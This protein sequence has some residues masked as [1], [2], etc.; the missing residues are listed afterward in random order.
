MTNTPQHDPLPASATRRRLLQQTMLLPWCAGAVAAPAA[1]S[2]A[3]VAAPAAA[4]APA[5]SPPPAPPPA[6]PLVKAVLSTRELQ[7]DLSLLATL[8]ETLHPGLLRFQ[9]EADY[10]ARRQSLHQTFSRDLPLA[11]A[12]RELSRFTAA[13]RCGHTY[14]NFYNQRRSVQQAL[15]AGRDKLPFTFTWLGPRMVATGGALARGTEVLAIDGT[16]VAD[17][18]AQLLPLVRTDGN[19][20]AKKLALLSVRG[21][22]AWETFDIFFAQTFGARDAGLRRFVLD[23]RLPGDADQG[24]TRRL[25]VPA[26]GLE[27]RR[28]AVPPQP[29]PSDATPP[30]QLRFESSGS[31]VLTMGGWALYNSRWDWQ[32][33]LNAVLD[34]VVE[35]RSPALVVDLRDNEGGMDCGDLILA[36]C[37]ARV[38]R[39]EGSERLVRYRRVPDALRAPLDTWDNNF[40]DWGDRV[41]PLAGARE[42]RGDGAS[43]FRFVDS[44]TARSIEP[45]G[46]RFAGALRVL[47]S[48]TNSSATFR[49]AQLVRQY[50][51][52]TLIGG[53]TGGNQRGITGG[54]FFFVRLPETGLEVDLP[55]IGQYARGDRPDAGIE[56]DLA[57]V[58]TVADIAAGRDPVLAAALRAT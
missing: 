9:T 27:E 5:G 15:F 18:L 4:S 10:R 55:L 8:Y 49:F 58:P 48:S 39:D 1:D 26:V 35:R 16:P 13:V 23:V 22:D 56:P 25:E 29:A 12:F 53:A 42:G 28:S 30:W 19:N 31:A 24:S 50:G 11:T 46:P 7:A 38:L 44:A 41:E 6:L 52:G 47:T 33:W 17:V 3:S 14:A 43:W 20:D 2:P 21:R 54:G 57:R 34:E 45:R 32:R 36:R 40:F 51:L 37:T